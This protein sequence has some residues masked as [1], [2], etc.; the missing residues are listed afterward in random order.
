MMPE[1]INIPIIG[2]YIKLTKP[3]AFEVA[4]NDRNYNMYRAV[5]ALVPHHCFPED[6]ITVE[7][8]VETILLVSGLELI[9]LREGYYKLLLPYKLNLQLIWPGHNGKDKDIRFIAKVDD[10]NN[11]HGLIYQKDS[12]LNLSKG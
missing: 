2:D 1:Q 10:M 12:W 7:L 11:I 3:W 5:N 4:F 6:P 8:P 9:Y